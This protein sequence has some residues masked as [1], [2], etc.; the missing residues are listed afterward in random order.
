M[1]TTAEQEEEAPAKSEV[2]VRTFIAGHPQ[3]A[4]RRQLFYVAAVLATIV[5]AFDSYSAFGVAGAA[6]AI[7]CLFL[8][9]TTDQ[10]S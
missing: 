1:V 8:L 6:V 2:F 3:G 9:A 7:T 10:L 4:I 5:A